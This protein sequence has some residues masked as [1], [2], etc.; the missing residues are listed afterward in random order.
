MPIPRDKVIDQALIM[1]LHIRRD[2]VRHSSFLYERRGGGE[3]RGNPERTISSRGLEG[4]SLGVRRGALSNGGYKGLI[5][6]ALFT[7]W[8]GLS[9]NISSRTTRTA[10]TNEASRASRASRNAG[11]AGTA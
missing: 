1:H 3:G 9:V 10:R 11:T 7:S 6:P 2:M 5:N 4:G 8:Q